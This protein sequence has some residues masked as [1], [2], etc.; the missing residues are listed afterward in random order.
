[1]HKEYLNEIW[2]DIKGYEGLYQVSNYGRVKSLPKILPHNKGG[3]RITKEKL[4]LIHKTNRGYLQVGL[5][6]NGYEKLFSVHRLVAQ[7]FIPNPHNY[8]CVNHKDENKL[9]NF[10]WV[11]E[12]GTVDLEKSNLEWCTIKYNSN[13]GTRN[14]RLSLSKRKFHP[15]AKAIKQ[16][17]LDGNFIKEWISIS[18]IKREYNYDTSAISRCCK[19]KYK[20]AYGYVW[21]YKSI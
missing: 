10:V 2:K 21:K 17:D 18:E 4:L 20:M 3:V 6:V 9:N 5:R 15:K 14:E 16:F 7:A 11:N 1:M 13:Y 8:P 19:G 12:D